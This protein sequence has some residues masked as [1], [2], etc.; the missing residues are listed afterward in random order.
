[1]SRGDA[2]RRALVDAFV[3][4]GALRFGDV[5]LASGRTSP[6]YVDA[7]RALTEPEVLRAISKAMAPFATEADR[8][9]GVELGAIP[10]AAAV[11]LETGKPYVMVRRQPKEHG[12]KAG[13]EGALRLAREVGDRRTE[14]LALTEI[15]TG[16]WDETRLDEA[17]RVGLQAL[18]ILRATGDH[19]ATAGVMNLLSMTHYMSHDVHGGLRWAEQ[20]L[21]EA[22]LAGDRAREATALSY[23]GT[24]TGA[25]GRIWYELLDDLLRIRYYARGEHLRRIPLEEVTPISPEV[26]LQHKQIQVDLGSQELFCYEYKRLVFR[27]R[28]SSGIPDSRPRENGIPTI[29]PS[30]RFF[31]EV[32]M[33]SRHMGN[34]RITADLEAY[35]LPGVPWVSFFTP[36]GVAFHGTY[37]HNDFGRPKSRGCINMDCSEAKWVYRWTLP[38]VPPEQTRRIGRG[39]SILIG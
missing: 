36:T 12:T 4:T 23:L 32:K 6:Y 28:I 29:T 25:D 2:D 7:K 3:R 16:H 13:Y 15:A 39:T 10:I 30:G 26:P 5:T 17:A 22:R 27:T 1:V 24:L 35:E 20:A 34:G 33:P 8:I 37:W 21:A 38:V 14:G 18:E 9:A 19:G 31:I 11:A